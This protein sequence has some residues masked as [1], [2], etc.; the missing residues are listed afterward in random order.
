M[1]TQKTSLSHI[2][3]RVC[4]N[5][6]YKGLQKKVQAEVGEPG[7][8]RSF[9]WLPPTFDFVLNHFRP[10]QQDSCLARACYV[11]IH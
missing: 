8:T 4:T 9:Q 5:V 6:T 11:C 1:L 7:S 3:V 10:P 2:T